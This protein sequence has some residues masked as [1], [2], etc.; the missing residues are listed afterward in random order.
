MKIVKKIIGFILVFLSITILV[1]VYWLKSYFGLVSI[2]QY[3]F[4]L[5]VPLDETNTDVFVLYMRQAMIAILLLIIIYHLVIFLRTKYQP[6]LEIKIGRKELA[7]NIFPFTGIK[8]HYFKVSAILFLISIFCASFSLGIVEFLKNYFDISTI[9]EDYYVSPNDVDITFPEKKRNLILIHLESMETTY[10]SKENG[11]AFDYD[12][13]EPLSNLAKNNVNFSNSD[14]LGGAYQ[15]SGAGWT[16]AGMVSESSGIPLKVPIDGNTYGNYKEFLPNNISL[17]DILKEQGY[18]QMIMVGSNL[19]FGGRKEFYLQHGNYMVFDLDTA[20][21]K[22]LIPDDY[23]IWW[24]FEDS[25][26]FEYAKDEIT[27]LARMDKPFNFTMLTSNTHFIGGYLENNCPLTFP[28]KYTNA[29]ACSSKQIA[30]FVKWITEQEFYED[31]TIVL[32]GDHLTMDSYYMSKIDEKYQRN[33][34]NTFVN[35]A[36]DPIN[37]KNREFTTMDYFP[38]ILA[39]MGVKIEGNRLG[40]GTNLFS[41]EETLVEKLGFENFD[42]ELKKRSIFYNDTFIYNK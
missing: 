27:S 24:G 15:T 31:T 21:K 23:F 40:L 39:S 4:H 10:T 38:S 18:N 7:I 26:L 32:I 2:E 35:S 33:V 36:I 22:K 25:K 1:S 42:N 19:S 11:G 17:G 34:F 28:S 16:T 30:D 5:A 14:R 41:E 37:L 29:L 6:Q 8:K 13:I 3:L 9:Y 20:K 12:I